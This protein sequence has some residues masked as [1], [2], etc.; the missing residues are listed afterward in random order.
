MVPNSRRKALCSVP[1]IC[2][3]FGPRLGRLVPEQIPDAQPVRARDNRGRQRLQGTWADRGDDRGLFA[4]HPSQSRSRVRRLDFTAHPTDAY[5]PGFLVNPQ[6][7]A[8][9]GRAMAKD[10]KESPDALQPKPQD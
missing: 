9:L 1:G 4:A 7:L 6:D 10:A 2:C 5:Q 8:D 3:I